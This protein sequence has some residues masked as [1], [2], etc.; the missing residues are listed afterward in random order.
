MANQPLFVSNKDESP[1]IFK[2]PF[3][4]LMSRVHW[5]APLIMWGPVVL[6]CIYYSIFKLKL[7][8]LNLVGLYAVAFLL[9]TLAEYTLHRFVFHFHPSSATGKR[10]MFLIHG[11]HHDYPNDSKRLVMPPMLSIIISVP[12]IA[13]FYYTM[14]PYHYI[15]FAGFASGYLVYDM[16]H[17]A[18]HHANVNWPFFKRLKEHHM[19]HHYQEPDLGFGV[20][21]TLWDSIFGTTLIPK[22]KKNAA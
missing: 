7:P 1:R 18:L 21:N 14:N 8:L 13:L 2:N 17:Y 15:F 20:S 11:V 4:D 19:L 10:I 16:M 12:F 6:F 5:S 22:N 3:L 9:W